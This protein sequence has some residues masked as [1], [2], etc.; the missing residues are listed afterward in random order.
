MN[1]VCEEQTEKMERQKTKSENGITQN[2]GVYISIWSEMCEIMK[3]INAKMKIG[4]PYRMTIII[5]DRIDIKIISKLWIEMIYWNIIQL[6]FKLYDRHWIHIRWIKI[7]SIRK[8]MIVY[9]ASLYHYQQR[10]LLKL[11]SHISSSCYCFAFIISTLH[12]EN[13]LSYHKISYLLQ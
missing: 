10:K 1:K 3:K 12:R 2:I 13:F 11:S 4:K 9:P 6:L 8:M 7:L 5:L